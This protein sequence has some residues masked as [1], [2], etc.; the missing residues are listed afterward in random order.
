MQ[1]IVLKN[2]DLDPTAMGEILEFRSQVFE[3]VYQLASEKPDSYSPEKPDD[4]DKQSVHFILRDEEG[5]I[6]AYARIIFG[7]ITEYHDT[8]LEGLS[9]DLQ[10]ANICCGS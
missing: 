10:S 5:I 7:Q 8:D 3:E 2:E 6:R 1:A 4:Y 9:N